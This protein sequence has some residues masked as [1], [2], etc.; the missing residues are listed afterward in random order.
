LLIT[1][2][3]ERFLLWHSQLTLKNAMWAISGIRKSGREAGPGQKNKEG[4][5]F[6]I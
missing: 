1:K 5:P 4:V 3:F 2:K 6:S